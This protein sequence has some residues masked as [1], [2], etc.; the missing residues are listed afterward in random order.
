[1]GDQ[2]V[3]AVELVLLQVTPEA[4][5]ILQILVLAKVITA[6]QAHQ[7]LPRLIQQ[8]LVVEVGQG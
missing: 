6:E 1:M 7:F 5:V 2:V 3:V 4:L 8:D